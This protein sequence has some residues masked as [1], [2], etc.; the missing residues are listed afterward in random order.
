M[1]SLGT[2]LLHLP[3]GKQFRTSAKGC[4]ANNMGG[5]IWYTFCKRGKKSPVGEEEGMFGRFLIV[6]KNTTVK[7]KFIFNKT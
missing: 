2:E 4:N 6:I 3:E 1:F 7:T 5:S